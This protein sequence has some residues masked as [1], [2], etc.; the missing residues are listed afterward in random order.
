MEMDSSSFV[1]NCTNQ[2]LYGAVAEIGDSVETHQ[3]MKEYK[4]NLNI[5]GF[6]FRVFS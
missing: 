4:I 5:F 6:G 2:M 1:L 3:E